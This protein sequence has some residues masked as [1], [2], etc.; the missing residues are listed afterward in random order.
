MRNQ[1][2]K[3]LSFLAFFTAEILGLLLV[4]IGTFA[5]FF[6]LTREVF[7]VKNHAFDKWAFQQ[8]DRITT[9]FLT[10]LL[11]FVTFFGSFRFFV[12]VP[13]ALSLFFL[14]FKNWRWFSA[15]IFTG[16]LGSVLLN[17]YLKNN[18]VR[19]RP[20]SALYFQNGFSFPSGH[21]MIGATFYGVLIYLIW[22]NARNKWVKWLSCAFLGAFQLMIAFSR[23]Y[24]NVHYATDVLAGL[25]AGIFWLF[26]VLLGLRHLEKRYHRKVESRRRKTTGT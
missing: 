5:A 24:L 19:P 26:L 3:E 6:Y 11:E 4:F 16:T 20:A 14:F 10:D 23:V 8:T 2:K 18:F 22:N 13:I 12:I 9:P 17:Q 7:I 15:Y 25:A 1:T 21:A